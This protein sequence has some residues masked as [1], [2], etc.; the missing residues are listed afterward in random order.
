M[1]DLP[2]HAPRYFEDYVPGLT[3]DCGAFSIT[4]AEI[5]AFAKEYDPQPFHIDPLA[6][7]A[8]PFGGLIASGWQTTS[9]MMRLLVEHFVSPESGLGAAGVDEIRW[10]KPVR[11]GDTLHV[12]AT[13]LEARRSSS[14]PDRG[15]VRSLAEVTNQHGDTVMRVTAINFVRLR[16][17]PA[18]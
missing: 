13:V 2:E 3:V 12:R 4:E 10:P 7:A 16:N 18:A 5:I 14:K 6:A 9:M 17:H 15:I 11:P 1:T 8:G